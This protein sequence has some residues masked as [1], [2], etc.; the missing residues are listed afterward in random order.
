MT[1]APL[2]SSSWTISSCPPYEAACRALPYFPPLALTSALLSSSSWTIS[3]YPS[4]EAACRALPYSPPSLST[5][6]PV[7]DELMTM[8]VANIFV[9]FHV[10]F[11]V[12]E[13]VVVALNKSVKISTVAINAVGVR[14]SLFRHKSGRSI[15]GRYLFSRKA[16]FG[17][18]RLLAPAN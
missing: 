11:C 13:S 10:F 16:G 9:L 7:G 2:S 3:G 18:E 4:D 17:Q 15:C 8:E 12:F 5:S 6:A 1:S 14:A